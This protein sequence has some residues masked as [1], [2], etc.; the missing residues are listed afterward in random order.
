MPDVIR[1][2]RLHRRA[3][4]MKISI[5]SV[6]ALEASEQREHDVAETLASSAK[7]E[8]ILDAD[9]LG[10]ERAA[11]VGTRISTGTEQPA[12]KSSAA[13]P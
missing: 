1:F 3:I 8:C 2:G 5:T 11:H 13:G 6:L 9:T 12:S 4:A 10:S 7:K